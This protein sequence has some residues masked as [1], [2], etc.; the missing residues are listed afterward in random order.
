MFLLVGM[1]GFWCLGLRFVVFCGWCWSYFGFLIW[2]VERVELCFR[3]GRSGIGGVEMGLRWFGIWK[4]LSL[5]GELI[6]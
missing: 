3:L 5:V 2:V 4:C 6:V 1:G